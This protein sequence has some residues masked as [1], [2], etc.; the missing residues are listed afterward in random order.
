MEWLQQQKVMVPQ[1]WSLELSDPVV[2]GLGSTEGWEDLFHI[3]QLLGLCWK[4]LAFAGSYK[5][6]PNLCLQVP[7]A[8]SLCMCLCPLILEEGPFLPQHDLI[9]TKD[10]SN[11]PISKSGDTLRSWWPRCEHVNGGGGHNSTPNTSFCLRRSLSLEP[12]SPNGPASKHPLASRRQ[13]KH[14]SSAKASE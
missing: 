13:L 14:C 4:L 10:V 1:F 5:H 7:L 8:F 6:H 3:P 9:L 2:R 11:D 12:P